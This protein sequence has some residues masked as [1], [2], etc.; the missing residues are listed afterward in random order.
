MDFLK[1][2]T[3]INGKYLK[4]VRFIGSFTGASALTELRRSL[5]LEQQPYLS[6]TLLRARSMFMRWPTRVTPK[7]R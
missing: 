7:S 5:M 1:K 6:S 3:L 2:L 4:K